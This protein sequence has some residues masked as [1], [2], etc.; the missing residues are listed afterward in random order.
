MLQFSELPTAGVAELADA[1]DLG[2]NSRRL[3]SRLPSFQAHENSGFD[4]GARWC[5]LV[6]F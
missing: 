2:A 4:F 5:S 1:Q 6:G 3:A